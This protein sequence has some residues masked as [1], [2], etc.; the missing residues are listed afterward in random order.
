MKCKSFPVRKDHNPCQDGNV[1]PKD[2]VLD[3]VTEKNDV[4]NDNCN[5]V[6]EINLGVG[7]FFV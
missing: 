5:R 4:G 7:V 6:C 2:I 1:F 3:A